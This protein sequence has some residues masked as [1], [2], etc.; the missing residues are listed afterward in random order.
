M[1]R[2]TPVPADRLWMQVEFVADGTF[3]IEDVP[4]G[5]YEL[6]LRRPGTLDYAGTIRVTFPD[7]PGGRSDRPLDLGT[8]TVQ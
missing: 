2:V 4:P 3:R 7:I 5:T 1:E 8:L 6:K